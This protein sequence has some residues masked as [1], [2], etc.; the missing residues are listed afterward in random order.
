MFLLVLV[1]VRVERE[2]EGAELSGDQ[3]GRSAGFGL[4][5]EGGN[6]RDTRVRSQG[7]VERV[8]ESRGS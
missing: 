6:K 2:V 3:Q 4:E 7:Q 1:R 8:S 5:Q